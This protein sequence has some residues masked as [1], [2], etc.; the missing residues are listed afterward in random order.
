MPYKHAAL[1]LLALIFSLAGCAG[2]NG[3]L[4]LPTRPT[5]GHWPPRGCEDT[6][7]PRI[8]QCGEERFYAYI[9][10]DKGAISIRDADTANGAQA[11]GFLKGFE[12]HGILTEGSVLGKTFD[13]QLYGRAARC[14]IARGTHRREGTPYFLIFGTALKKAPYFETLICG[15]P[16]RPESAEFCAAVFKPADQQATH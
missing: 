13:C 10:E 5:L 15:T 14:M 6:D 4:R 12:E 8:V 9:P 7:N 16:T 1:S 2:M 3:G 11:N